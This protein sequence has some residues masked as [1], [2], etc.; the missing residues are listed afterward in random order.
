MLLKDPSH[1]RD[2][3]CCVCPTLRIN[4]KKNT[5]LTLIQS[6]L[7]AAEAEPQIFGLNL[8]IYI[9]IYISFTCGYARLCKKK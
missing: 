9:Y 6:Y 3:D 4:K 8:Y 5:Y 1:L 2:T 7:A